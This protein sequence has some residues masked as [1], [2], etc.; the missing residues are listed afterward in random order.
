MIN[1]HVTG[2]TMFRFTGF[3][4]D[5]TNVSGFGREMNGV[6]MTL[7]RVQIAEI[8]SAE[9]TIPRFA[10]QRVLRQVSHGEIIKIVRPR[11]RGE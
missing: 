10:Q 4:T 1:G 11:H 9:R 3:V 6:Q 8:F 7:G 5:I 2:K